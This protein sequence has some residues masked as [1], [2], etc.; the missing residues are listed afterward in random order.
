MVAL[1]GED[2]IDFWDKDAGESS[3]EFDASGSNDNWCCCF[4]TNGWNLP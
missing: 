4:C 3:F 1:F 2:A